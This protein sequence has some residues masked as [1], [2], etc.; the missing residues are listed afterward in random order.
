VCS[1]VCRWGKKE[2]FS[3]ECRVISLGATSGKSNL[4]F[5]FWGGKNRGRCNHH[6][7]RFPFSCSSSLFSSLLLN[8]LGMQCSP[9]SRQP[10]MGWRCL[11]RTRML[12]VWSGFAGRYTEVKVIAAMIAQEG[13]G[14]EQ[15]PLQCDMLGSVHGERSAGPSRLRALRLGFATQLCLF[16]FLFCLLLLPQHFLSLLQQSYCSWITAGSFHSL[17]MRNSCTLSLE[18]EPYF[19]RDCGEGLQLNLQQEREAKA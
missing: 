13:H 19:P 2:A 5:F 12:C 6:S 15:G 10:Q 18:T 3:F 1:Q 7:N 16:D 4:S 11:G 17:L 14:A 8:T 9:C